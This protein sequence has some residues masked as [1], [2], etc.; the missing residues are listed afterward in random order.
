MFSK[1]FSLL[2]RSSADTEKVSRT[3]A[4]GLTFAASF[5]TMVFGLTDA[6]WLNLS[7]QITALITDM[8]NLINASLV[9]V[10]LLKAVYYGLVRIRNSYS[11]YKW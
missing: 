3:V 10:S 5:A 6:Q 8:L 9:V 2:P 7:E 4:W 11:E 1:L